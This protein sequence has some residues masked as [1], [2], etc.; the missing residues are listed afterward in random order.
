MSLP[1]PPK[2]HGRFCALILSPGALSEESIVTV[3]VVSET[4][5]SRATMAALRWLVVTLHF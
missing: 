3:E 4:R 1:P 2:G 5:L